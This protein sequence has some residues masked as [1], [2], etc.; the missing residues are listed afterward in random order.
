MLHCIIP[1]NV[2]AAVLRTMVRAIHDN[3]CVYTCPRTGEQ[4]TMVWKFV[5]GAV[6]PVFYST[7]TMTKPMVHFVTSQLALR[8]RERPAINDLSITYAVESTRVTTP[9]RGK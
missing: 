6:R 5:P 9:G 1:G 7:T 4:Q 2:P 8:V 3:P